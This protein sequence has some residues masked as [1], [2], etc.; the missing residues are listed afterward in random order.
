MSE[1]EKFR[2]ELNDENDSV[3][4]P[5]SGRNEGLIRSVPFEPALLKAFD[6]L[7]NEI[8]IFLLAYVILLIGL[9]VFADELSETLKNLLYIIPIMGAGT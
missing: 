8:L 3:N 1:P 5:V 2:K 9:G 7:T 6:K 4:I